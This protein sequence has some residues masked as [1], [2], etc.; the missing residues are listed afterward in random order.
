MPNQTRRAQWTDRPLRSWLHAGKGLGPDSSSGFSAKNDA[1]REVSPSA[2]L[3]LNGLDQL[4]HVQP[5][6]SVMPRRARCALWFKKSLIG[7]VPSDQ[8]R[9][10]AQQARKAGTQSSPSLTTPQRQPRCGHGPI[11]FPQGEREPHEG[12]VSAMCPPHIA[13]TILPGSLA[14]FLRCVPMPG[15]ERGRRRSQSE[16]K[17]M[18]PAQLS[19]D[20]LKGLHNDNDNLCCRAN[21]AA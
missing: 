9:E 2:R 12:F 19:I 16:T 20:Q 13:R 11:V 15:R 7:K 3:A 4:P 5:R 14:A 10:P 6:E 17:P 1:A 21:R 18:P 8:H